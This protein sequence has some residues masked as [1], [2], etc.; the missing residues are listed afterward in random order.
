MDSLYTPSEWGQRFHDLQGGP[1]GIHEALGAGAAGPGKSMV[2]LMD[3]T[4][5]ILVEHDRCTDKHHPN[6]HP[7]G[8]STGWAL[9]LRRTRPMLDQ[10]IARSQ[11]IFPTM[12]P[13]AKYNSANT[14]W[15]FSSGF[16]Y[17]FG[18]C[19]DPDDW[20]IYMS[21][22]YTWIGFDELVQFEQEQYLQI[23][24]RLRSGDP[25]LRHMTKVRACSNPVLSVSQTIGVT[26]NDP[27]WVRKYFVEPEPT[28]E[29]I[30]KKRIKARDGRTKWRRR[31]YLPAT[32]YDNPDPDFVEDYEATLLGK[33]MHIQKAL[34][35]GDWWVSAGSFYGESWN[36]QIHVCEPFR[37]PYEWPIFRSMDWGYKK[38]GTV[39]WIALDPDDNMYVYREYTFQEKTDAEVAEQIKRIEKD[40]GLWGSGKSLITG[41]ADTQL[42]EKRG[43]SGKSKA[44]VMAELGVH[45]QKAD[46][47]PGSRK[48]NAQR[49]LKRMN[50]HHGGHTTPGIV[51]FEGCRMCRTTIPGV[52]TNPKDLEEPADGG[53][54]H[55]HDA[56]L[57]ACAHA[58]RGRGT[59]HVGKKKDPWE[60]DYER[61]NV[62]DR[63]YDGYGSQ[64]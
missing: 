52:Q 35:Y 14:T 51:F 56:V 53:E 23:S 38:P 19:K 61:D 44:E 24:G 3:P 11:R 36:D 18:H 15:Q 59:I 40:E 50:D 33:P 20:D 21:N 13:G 30:L 39:L 32:L 63:G 10:T 57:Y 9:H 54:D 31:I 64:I 60:D 45:W 62:G 28:G 2:L 27:Q 17:Q 6:Y 43:D 47:G 5:Q 8:M 4:D 37:I 49:L 22:E 41:P 34:L 26:I 7:W 29:K 25:I 12:D 16:R 42:W 1:D 48:S 58:S 55:W 46:K